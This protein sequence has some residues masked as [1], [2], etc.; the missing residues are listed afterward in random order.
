VDVNLVPVGEKVG[1]NVAVKV[2]ERVEVGVWVGVAVLGVV[3]PAWADATLSPNEAAII[4]PIKNIV[5]KGQIR[6][7]L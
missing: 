5:T 2:G 4:A 7:I 3:V 6:P 1:V